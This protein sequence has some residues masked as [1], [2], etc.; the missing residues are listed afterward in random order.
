M[1]KSK[2][3]ISL[4][5]V[6]DICKSKEDNERAKLVLEHTKQFIKIKTEDAIKLKE[7]LQNL[8]MAK[9]K[10]LHIV[11]IID[12]MPEDAE[13]VRK[14]FVDDISLNQ[15]EIAKILEAVNKYRK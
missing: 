13:D 5:E 11:K 1:I 15:D 9:L 10:L 3:P 7:G 14:I 12:L 4:A 6:R 8:G 2:E